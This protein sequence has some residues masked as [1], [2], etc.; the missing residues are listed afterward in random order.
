M[1]NL[2]E[3]ITLLFIIYLE[4]RLASFTGFSLTLAFFLRAIV[5]TD[6]PMGPF[7]EQDISLWL[8]LTNEFLLTRFR[9]E[10]SLQKAFLVFKAI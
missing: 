1:L 10:I 7:D 8:F 5:E 9:G 4:D 6:L 3:L 2:L